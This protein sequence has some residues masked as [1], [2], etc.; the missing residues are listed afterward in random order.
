VEGYQI[1]YDSETKLNLQCI[2]AATTEIN[3]ASNRDPSAFKQYT[4][5]KNDMLRK[6]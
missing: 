6:E 3:A 4:S 2:N 1:N 5:C